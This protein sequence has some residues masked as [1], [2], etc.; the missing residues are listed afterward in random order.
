MT[1]LEGAGSR[2]DPLAAEGSAALARLPAASRFI[3][4]GNPAVL[5]AA[6]NAFGV[7]LPQLPC[8]AATAAGGAALGRAALWLG[9][10]EWLLLAPESD[11]NEIAASVGH[12]LAGIPHSL[13]EV[14]HRQ[15]GIAI[16]GPHAELILSAGCPLDLDPGAFPVAM[17]TRT[18]F[19]KIEIML[20]RTAPLAF[21]VEV[22]RSFAA[23]AWRLLAEAAREFGQ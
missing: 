18:V 15:I 17:C 20:W 23:Y 2:R 1:P 8:R 19:G 10:D 6:E 12:A 9:P 7:A 21:R 3:L 22:G 14:S 13:V 4:R 16:S 5:G 11:G